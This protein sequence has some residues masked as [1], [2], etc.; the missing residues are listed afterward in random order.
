MTSI[1]SSARASTV[2]AIFL[3]LFSAGCGM[4]L[5]LEPGECGGGGGG[6]VVPPGGFIPVA[7][8]L[9]FTSFMA[10]SLHRDKSA[11]Q[12]TLLEE[13]AIGTSALPSGH[14]EVPKI[15]STA[16]PVI[17][18]NDAGIDGAATFATRPTINCGTTQTTI[19]QRIDHC[20]AQNGALASWDGATNG[21]SGQGLWKL[22]TRSGAN[23]VWRDE[24]TG[25]IW[26]SPLGVS[27]NWCRASGNSGGGPFGQV[28]AFNVCDNVANQDQVTPESMCTEAAGLNTSAAYDAMKGGMRLT[29]TGSSPSVVW[30][31]PTKNDY[32]L[33]EMNGIRFVVPVAGNFFWTATVL[34][35]FRDWAWEWADNF[36]QIGIRQRV[37]ATRQVRCVGRPGTAGT[38]SG[39]ESYA[40]KMPS[41]IHRN[42]G[43]TVITLEQEILA[44]QGGLPT[45]YREIPNLNLDDEGSDDTNVAPGVRPSV[46]CGTTQATVALR[47]ANCAAL[48]GAVA[49]WEGAANANSGQATWKLVTYN[50]TH[51]VWRDERTKL[52]WTDTLGQTNWC[53]ASGSSGGGPLFEDDISNYC[54]NAGNQNQVT[55]ES[56]C[57]E[58]AGFNTPGAY[59]SMKGGMR[60]AA[61]AT[62][63]A[64]VWRLPTVWDYNLA[65]VDGIRFPKPTAVIAF[66]SA[67]AFSFVR[68]NGWFFYGDRGDIGGDDRS[69]PATYYVKCVGRY[70]FEE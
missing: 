4:G 34:S 47:I 11:T 46:V 38:A 14:R 44:G 41:M 3:G 13:L 61:T 55:P 21:N 62:S 25:L 60:L 58:N 43:A 10:S 33:A 65:E 6:G 17:G 1:R 56:W 51:E 31:L 70:A 37:T 20:F 64:V 22:V 39:V 7:D 36:G 50:G 54:D 67:S 69:T 2:I 66:W 40:S 29:A 63:P 68:A 16:P 5:C 49:T 52:L 30:R 24:R 35:T 8:P 26:S 18:D 27:T 42:K 48:N 59:D 28:D 23:E 15:G 19:A 53:R 57:A 9:E 12:L 32:H 45:G